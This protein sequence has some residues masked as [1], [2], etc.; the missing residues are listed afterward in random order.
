MAAKKADE[1]KAKNQAEL[2]KV[3]KFHK[4]SDEDKAKAQALLEKAEAE[5]QGNTY[6]EN[7]KLLQEVAA[8]IAEGDAKAIGWYSNSL[9]IGIWN[10]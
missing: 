4:A 5:I 9:Y 1:E 10:F 3:F 7:R 6:E 2:Q 8:K